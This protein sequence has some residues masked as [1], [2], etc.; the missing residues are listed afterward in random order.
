MNMSQKTKVNGRIERSVDVEIIHEYV[1]LGLPSGL[2]WATCNVGATKPEEYGG[3]YAWGETKEKN[4]FSWST[5]KWCNG[6]YDTMTKYSIYS[7]YGTVDNRIVLDPV[8]DVAHVKW[9]GCWRMPTRAERDELRSY[10][11][12]IWTTQN[13]V[14]GYRVTGPSGNSIFFPAAGY[15][16]STDLCSSGNDGYYWLSSLY[17]GHS[18]NA[19]SLL[20]GSSYYGWGT[21]NRNNGLSVRP[22][23]GELTSTISVNCTYGGNVAID[24]MTEM[25]ILKT[26]GKKVTVVATPDVDCDFVGWYVNGAS[27]PVNTDAEYAFTV[28]EEDMTLT[29][30]FKRRKTY[31]DDHKYADVGESDAIFVEEE[32][33]KKPFFDFVEEL[34]E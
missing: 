23:Y 13:G 29:A 10:C 20:F 28:T 32:I 8:D 14:N 19:Y 3:Y 5:Y 30:K 34:P 1:D 6:S 27:T 31:V 22:V 15:R 9:G 24:G 2:K 7:S 18:N 26:L 17:E 12:W 4:D 11:T 21:L 33:E 25:S 16:N